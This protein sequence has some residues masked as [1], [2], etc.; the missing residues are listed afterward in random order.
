MQVWDSTAA[1]LKHMK[2]AGFYI[3]AT[4]LA[5]ESIPISELDWTRP[6]VIIL[7]NESYGAELLSAYI[8][9]ISGLHSQ[10]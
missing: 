3:A 10:S 8:P 6:T 9:P 7:G 1:C 4:H 5:P 2:S